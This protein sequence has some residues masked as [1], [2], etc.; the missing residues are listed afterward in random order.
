MGKPVRR[1]LRQYYIVDLSN[2]EQF[3]TLEKCI[4]FAMET[5]MADFVI[6]YYFI[7]LIVLQCLFAKILINNLN[8]NLTFF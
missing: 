6:V 3:T 5:D 8:F 7:K 1:F 2:A 4:G